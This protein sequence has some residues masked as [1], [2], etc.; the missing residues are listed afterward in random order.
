MKRVHR[1]GRKY[2]RSAKNWIPQR[3][4]CY[5]RAGGVCEVS[6]LSLSVEIWNDEETQLLGIRWNRACHHVIAERFVRK[7]FK[8]VSPH[9]LENLL[10]VTPALHSKL[11]NAENKLFK[12]DWLGYR[13]EL[14]RLGMDLAVLDRAFRALCSEEKRVKGV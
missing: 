9:I 2:N 6:G 12:A 5:E 4:A 3:D 14:H 10:A 8:G 11:T 1:S 13:T 7:F